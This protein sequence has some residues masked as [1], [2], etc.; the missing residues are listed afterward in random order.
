MF[1]MDRPNPEITE[2]LVERF[3][4]NFKGYFSKPDAKD[5]E[6]FNDCT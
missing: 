5:K 6:S 3:L 1:I 2:E 4:V